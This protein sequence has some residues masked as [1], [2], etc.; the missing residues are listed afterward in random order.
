LQ[1][2]YPFRFR[3]GA[4]A[5]IAGRKYFGKNAVAAYLTAGLSF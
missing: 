5:P 2:D 1:Y 3:L 4:A